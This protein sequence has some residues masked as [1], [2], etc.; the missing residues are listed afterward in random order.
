MG[1]VVGEWE[2]VLRGA[3]IMLC[4]PFGLGRADCVSMVRTRRPASLRWSLF[5]SSP[6]LAPAMP[7][8]NCTMVVVSVQGA[9]PVLFSCESLLVGPRRRDRRTGPY[10]GL[11]LLVDPAL[12]NA[13]ACKYCCKFFPTPLAVPG[14]FL[15]RSF[16]P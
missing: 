8:E 6:I 16:P 5:M 15:D 2:V 1:G 12:V 10:T 13:V 14:K 11:A 9:P 7:W 3:V 4:E